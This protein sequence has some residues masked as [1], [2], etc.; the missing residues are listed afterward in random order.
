MTRGQHPNSKAR[1]YRAT[2]EGACRRARAVRLR[3]D[4]LSLRQIAD[5]LGVS[6]QGVAF[7]LRTAREKFLASVEYTQYIE[8][9]P[10]HSRK[11]SRTA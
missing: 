7:M 6:K 9:R 3:Q 4:G 8:T 11:R 2:F 1:R 10:G 5:V